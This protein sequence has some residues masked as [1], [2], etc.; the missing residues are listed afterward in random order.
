MIKKN[1]GNIIIIVDNMQIISD[2]ASIVIWDDEGE[3]VHS[4]RANTSP[5]N[6][7]EAPMEITTTTYDCIQLITAQYSEKDILNLVKEK[8]ATEGLI[9]PE[10]EEQISKYVH[11][12]KNQFIH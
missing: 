9:T 1:N 5:Y 3:Y 2:Q 8:F 6:Q 12:I 7:A 4:I 10:V 11:S